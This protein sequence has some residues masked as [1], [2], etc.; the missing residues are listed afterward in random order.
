MDV[1]VTTEKLRTELY[2]ASRED[3]AAAADDCRLA[4]AAF[5]SAPVAVTAASR[6]FSWDT[7]LA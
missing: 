7:T 3:C 6:E 1:V 4:N 2:S 5:L